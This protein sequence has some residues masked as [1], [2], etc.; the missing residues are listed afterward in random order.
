MIG[1][2]AHDQEPDTV[3]RLEHSVHQSPAA[4]TAPSCWPATALAREEPALAVRATV[5]V[6]LNQYCVLGHGNRVTRT[7]RNV[8]M[9]GTIR[10]QPLIWCPGSMRDTPSKAPPFLERNCSVF[11]NHCRALVRSFQPELQLRRLLY[12]DQVRSVRP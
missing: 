4:P 12:C 2:P 11:S 7:G 10:T 8:C 1:R 5:L 9:H 3:P 6:V